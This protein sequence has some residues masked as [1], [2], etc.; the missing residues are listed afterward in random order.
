MQNFF[1]KYR[2]SDKRSRMQHTPILFAYIPLDKGGG[3]AHD[4]AYNRIYYMRQV[5]RQSESNLGTYTF[6]L[7]ILEADRVYDPQLANRP[8]P[9]LHAGRG[10]SSIASA[11]RARQVLA[12]GERISL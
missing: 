10:S 4:I 7:E 1:K 5:R 11:C 6:D 8:T 12:K 2:V 9:R 3:Y